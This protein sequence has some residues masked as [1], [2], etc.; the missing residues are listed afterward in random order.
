MTFRGDC[1]EIFRKHLNSEKPS[2]HSIEKHSP[3]AIFHLRGI[4]SENGGNHTISP[5][6][7]SHVYVSSNNVIHITMT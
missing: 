4:F 3:L 1:E 7:A 5:S 2:L 6:S